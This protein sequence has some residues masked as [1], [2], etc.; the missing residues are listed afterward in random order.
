MYAALAFQMAVVGAGG[1]AAVV[2][3]TEPNPPPQVGC[4]EGFVAGAGLWWIMT[5]LEWHSK[6][7]PAPRSSP[8]VGEGQ[9]Y[10]PVSTDAALKRLGTTLLRKI[11]H[12]RV[13]L[14]ELD[15]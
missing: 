3:F 10:Q 12:H 8:F 7:V 15:R 6:E 14:A 5:E 1:C 13:E 2:A 9:R 11:H 4:A